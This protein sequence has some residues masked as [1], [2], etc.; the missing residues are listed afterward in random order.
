MT[1]IRTVAVVEDDF[2]VRHSL[3]FLLESAGIE[4]LTFSSGELFLKS[5]DARAFGCLV[6]DVRM[7]GMSGI[8]L[9]HL[10]RAARPKLP[11][12]II[13][14]HADLDLAVE[15]M[16][17]GAVDFLTKPC[18]DD[19]FLD[20]VRTAL[21]RLPDRETIPDVQER[22]RQLS[23]RERE[24]LA[25]MLKGS[26]NKTIASELGISVRTVE[27]HRGRV[28]AKMGARNATDLVRM[29]MV[30]NGGGCCISPSFN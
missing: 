27:V 14:A 24:V 12:I 26:P 5:A 13:T 17:L 22:L 2:A 11:I 15:A 19:R 20:A 8:E 18:L 6:A 10:C 1:P 25:C 29:I 23:D 9:L 16:K 30:A 4:A 3:S 21:A 28:I 7:P